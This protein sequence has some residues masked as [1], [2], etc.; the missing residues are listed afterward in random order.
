MVDHAALRR[1]IDALE[2]SSGVGEVDADKMPLLLGRLYATY[3]QAVLEKHGI[4][5]D[6][7]AMC[8]DHWG[9][10]HRCRPASAVY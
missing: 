6:L 7:M 3:A 8:G 9:G 5:V 4:A 10:A 2:E 1:A